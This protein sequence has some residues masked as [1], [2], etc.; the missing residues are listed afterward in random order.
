ME[1]VDLMYI[2]VPFRNLATLHHYYYYMEQVDLMYISVPFRNLATL[3]HVY[4]YMAVLYGKWG[5]VSEVVPRCVTCAI[6]YP[7][8]MW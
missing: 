1:Q 2:S 7:C 5:N 3:H 4:Y 6:S 8:R